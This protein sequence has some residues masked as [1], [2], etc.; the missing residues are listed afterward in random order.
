LD[1]VY[2]E[3]EVLSLIEN[4]VNF[5]KNNAKPRQRLALLIEGIGKENFLKAIGEHIKGGENDKNS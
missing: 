5:Y 1:K 2:T 3:K 4:V